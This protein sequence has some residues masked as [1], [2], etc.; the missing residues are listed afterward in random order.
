MQLKI[1]KDNKIG[2]I[3]TDDL[4]KDSFEI[5]HKAIFDNNPYAS[6]R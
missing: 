2:Q 3:P 1:F 4:L 5:V 6:R